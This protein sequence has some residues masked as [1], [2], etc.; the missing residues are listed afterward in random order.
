MTVIK[1]QQKIIK[2]LDY[3]FALNDKVMY[4]KYFQKLQKTNVNYS[5]Y[6][7][8]NIS[9]KTAFTVHIQFN[10]PEQIIF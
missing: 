4:A 9:F 7:E 1:H 6:H 5:K 2:L 10:P 3:Y 8:K